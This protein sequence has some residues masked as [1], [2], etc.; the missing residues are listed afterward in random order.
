M[1]NIGRLTSLHHLL[2]D[3]PVWLDLGM[4]T[5]L[6]HIIDKLDATSSP[7]QDITIVISVSEECTLHEWESKEW[8]ALENAFL[9]LTSSSLRQVTIQVISNEGRIESITGLDLLENGLP[10]LVSRGLLKVEKISS[11]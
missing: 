5:Y 10:G 2:I 1:I 7:V 8:E 9:R 4:I 6:V 11:E 3:I